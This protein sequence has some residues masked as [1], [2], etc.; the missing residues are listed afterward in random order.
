MEPKQ[1]EALSDLLNLFDPKL[2]DKAMVKAGL[3][4]AINGMKPSTKFFADLDDMLWDQL[5][6]VINAFVDKF[7]VVTVEPLAVGDGEVY[8]V[9]DVD[10]YLGTFDSVDAE[11][12]KTLRKKPKLLKLV[13]EEFTI[14]E[15]AKLV[16]NPFLIGLLSIFGP[17][18]LDFI[19]S[20][21]SK[22]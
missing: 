22:N 19:R 10:A 2:M 15:Q 14:Q 13:K 18:I 4:T 12:K 9:A 16:G 20:W 3:G 5:K 21:L 11:V 1:L 6:N 7:G 17:L 8:T